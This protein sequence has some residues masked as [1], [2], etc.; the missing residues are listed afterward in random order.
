[1][2]NANNKSNKQN[3]GVTIVEA[4]AGS[5]KTYALSKRY[6]KLLLNSQPA[7]LSSALRSIL[8]ITFTNKATVEMKE[9]ILTMLKA[10]ALD[11]FANDTE[12]K[13]I[14][15]SMGIPSD[16]LQE[17]A[18]KA[19]G[20]LISNYSWFQVQ[21]IDSFINN[22]LMACALSIGRSSGFTIKRDYKR[23]LAYAFDELINEV[24]NNVKILNIFNDFLKHYLFVE[25]RQ[26]WFPKEDILELMSLFLNLSNRYGKDFLLKDYDA[27][28]VIIDKKHLV[29]LAGELINKAP[30]GLDKRV[31][32][33]IERFSGIGARGYKFDDIP[34]KAF[35]KE[36]V[37]MNKGFEADSEYEDLWRRARGKVIDI[38]FA[39]GNY[40]YAPYVK[41]FV[42]V[43]SLFKEASKKEDVLFLEELNTVASSII[44]DN[45]VPEIYYRL[46]ARY[47]HYLIDEF[48]DTSI[49]QWR[50]LQPMIE[51][52][53]SSGGTLFYV[54]DRKQSIFRFR[55]GESEIFNK[56]ESE[57]SKFNVEKK[58]LTTNWRSN[59]AIVEFNNKVFA[60]NN[61]SN[62]FSDKDMSGN[63]LPEAASR[64]ADIFNNVKQD[65]VDS[66]E[67]GYVQVAMID[68]KNQ[69]ERDEE[70][71]GRL[72]GIVE[73]LLSR[74]YSYR[75][76]ALLVRSGDEI[77]TVSAWFMS[78]GIGV[79]S[80]RTLN[81]F[82]RPIIKELLALLSFL[83]SP[84][85]DLNF[86]VFITGDIFCTA[87]GID[88]IVFRNFLF[89]LHSSKNKN[90]NLSLYS[91]FRNKF[92]EQ[93]DKF[94]K[95]LFKDVGFISVYEIVNKV[96]SILDVTENFPEQAAFLMK[97]LELIKDN[98]DEFVGIEDLLEYFNSGEVE[99]SSLQS[100]GL[101]VVRILTVHKAKGLEFPVVILPFLRMDISPE[102]AGKNMKLHIRND[103]SDKLD[104]LRIIQ[105]YRFFSDELD[106]VY[107]R[108]YEK[109]L[110]D[111]L[112]NMYVALTRAQKELYV[113]VP[114]KSG[115]SNNKVRLLI[116]EDYC[117]GVKLKKHKV[118]DDISDRNLIL[119]AQADIDWKNKLSGEFDIYNEIKNQDAISAGNIY[120]MIFSSIT[121]CSSSNYKDMLRD[122]SE[123]I[124]NFY[125]LN[126][127][128]LNKYI[129]DAEKLILSEEFKDIFFVNNA[130]VFCESELSDSNGNV[131]RPDRLI[132]T[133]DSV[134]V[135][136]YKYSKAH[137]Y[138]HHQQISEYCE[139]AR[140]V[141]AKEKV[142]AYII[143][144]KEKILEEI[145][146]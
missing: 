123:K 126:R 113:F 100:T 13:D 43:C 19:V 30:E 101:N 62:I 93:W 114:A 137:G 122:A 84:I 39:E 27:N 38:A 133:A 124:K 22:I 134:T 71:R 96:Y 145:K 66:R 146:L 21:T 58:F 95:G 46:S 12:K 42:L 135:V 91:V 51:D 15:E 70:I 79:E 132:V 74:G 4:S 2:R 82:D 53:L 141:Y 44:K 73:D 144:I 65:F 128:E 78:E 69:I 99:G 138:E 35:V 136:D 130:A 90:E 89:E 86:A 75:D 107:R 20:S 56:V 104:F 8:A 88:K 98:E 80:D 25:N 118:S 105:N 47:M 33:S 32:N 111:E 129:C 77:E 6:V 48:Q 36:N 17:V 108:D 87:C 143:F 116:N 72:K 67:S 57:F 14:L 34:V 85:D 63:V 11:S 37:P 16:S 92:P 120:H 121:D 97:F 115:Q 106:D 68:S 139:L 131:K 23:L 127:D 26:G 94:L 24:D 29:N 18:K 1:M 41:I 49:L 59:H 7:G 54:G 40:S 31:Y 61:L 50:N 64:V 125:S 83:A 9:R 3:F 52:A 140:A 102:S 117:C 76:I 119:K 110:I 10:I 109:A 112:N 103:F 142:K 81:V 5:G 28:Q 45:I 55:G 60:Q